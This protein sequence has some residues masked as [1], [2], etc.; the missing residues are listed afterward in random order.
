ME[1]GVALR[2]VDADARARTA[3]EQAR[4]IAESTLQSVRDLSQLL[5]PSMLDDFG[6]PDALRAHL[7]SFS[8][9]T[10]IR[11]QLTQERM[12][13]R[14]PTDVEVCVYRIV[15]EALTNVSRHS[16]ASSCTV[17]LVRRAGVLHLAIE[18]DGRGIMMPEL[19]RGGG[20][21]RRGLGLIGMRERAQALDGAFVIENRAE[22]GTRVTVKL[23]VPDAAAEADASQQ[24][25]G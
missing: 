17:S 8:K 18:D 24:R 19:A 25:A 10:N 15:Q 5:H 23:P 9:R 21:G 16:G 1:M 22:G 3:L 14:L 4:A 13:E 20:D 7:R 2:G 6:L 11:A 12:D